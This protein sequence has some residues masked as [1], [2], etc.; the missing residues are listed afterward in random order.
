MRRHRESDHAAAS[1]PRTT[2]RIHEERAGKLRE[3]AGCPTCH[4][5][6]RNGRWTWE[7]PPI[8]SY[9]HV[10]PAC[11]QIAKDDVGGELHLAGDFL[12]AHRGEIEACLRNVEEREKRE[13]PLKRIM[14]IR[15]EGGAVV[16]RVT[17]P[18]L[19]IQLGHAL[20]RAYDGELQLPA[21]SSDRSSPARGHWRRD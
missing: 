2:R 20:E 9:A 14:S 15:D 19:V 16:V 4:A 12:S 3:L 8:G 11:E 7:A 5:S 13:H 21:T 6:Y 10:C 18:K 17:D 1:G